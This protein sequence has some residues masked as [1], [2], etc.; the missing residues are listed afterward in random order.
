MFLCPFEPLVYVIGNFLKIWDPPPRFSKFRICNWELFD[1]G[2]YPPPLLGKVPKFSRFHI[3]MASLSNFV[4]PLLRKGDQSLTLHLR[5]RVSADA[6]AN[7]HNQLVTS[8][9]AHAL[10]SEAMGTFK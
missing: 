10:L 5:L 4:P 8:D 6:R 2:A 7:F 3:L 1:F 9:H